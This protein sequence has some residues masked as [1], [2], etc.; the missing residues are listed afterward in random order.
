MRK[1]EEYNP[2]TINGEKVKPELF[3]RHD[4]FV[5]FK[6]L[7]TKPLDKFEYEGQIGWFNDF[8][9]NVDKKTKQY[10]LPF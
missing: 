10:D 1:I 6:Q 4:S 8:E 3:R 9:H 5:T 2:Q 7:S